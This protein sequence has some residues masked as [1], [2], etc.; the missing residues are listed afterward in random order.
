MCGKPLYDGRGVI[1]LDNE[2]PKK[3]DVYFYKNPD[4]AWEKEYRLV[5]LNARIHAQETVPF[6]ASSSKFI[7][8][9]EEVIQL[10]Y[11]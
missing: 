3:G 1:Y 11:E 2:T 8:C 4:L 5:Y 9:I 6:V 10:N 7:K